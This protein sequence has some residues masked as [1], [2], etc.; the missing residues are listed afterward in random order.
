MKAGDFILDKTLLKKFAAGVNVNSLSRTVS[1]KGTPLYH[2]TESGIH[3]L[4]NRE[5]SLIFPHL[6]G[7]Y[8]ISYTKSS[9]EENQEKTLVGIQKG[10]RLLGEERWT[11]IEFFRTGVE[12]YSD[13]GGYFKE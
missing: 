5:Q 4:T 2:E 13:Q 1:Y 7:D 12:R 3:Y 8:R 11:G 6:D 10:N 9:L